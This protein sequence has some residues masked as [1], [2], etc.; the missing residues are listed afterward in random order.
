M[1]WDKLKEKIEKEKVTDQVAPQDQ[2]EDKIKFQTLSEADKK[3]GLKIGIYGGYATGKTHFALTCPEP[4]F[5][6][7]TEMGASPLAHLFKGKDIKVLDIAE[8]DGTLS[9]EKYTQAIDFLL[10]QD[11][12]GTIVVDS[13]TDIWSFCQEYSKTRVFKIK[14][15]QRLAQ[16]WDW[17]VINKLYLKPLLSLI[18]KDCHLVLSAREQ[19]IYAGAGNPTGRFESH[20]MKKTPY[21]IDYVLHNTKIITKT[22][23]VNFMTNVE[24]SRPLGKLMGKNFE[25]VNF[26]KFVGEIKKLKGEEK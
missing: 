1:A 11:K 12:V 16:Q 21:W 14:P 23:D 13:V 8:K 25:N 19:E 9:Y 4:I 24:K 3:R 7:D 5:I 17:G 15:E 6:I 26:D 10:K 20:W 22:G 2:E 18:K